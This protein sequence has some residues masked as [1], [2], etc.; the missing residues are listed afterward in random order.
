MNLFEELQERKNNLIALLNRVKEYGWLDA[1]ELQ[2]AIRKIRE[3][4]LTIG[5][6]GQMKCGKSTFL[7]SFIFE[8]EVL[9]AATTPMTAALS[10]ITYGEQKKIVA[11]FY[12]PD[13]WAE[14]RMQAHRSLDEVKGNN[15]EESKVQ[16]AQ[17]LVQRSHVLGSRIDSLLGKQQEDKFEHLIDY[18][19]AEGKYI[20]ITKSVTIYYPKEYLKGV[21]IVDTPGFNDPIVSREERTKAFLKN[22][23]VALMMLFAGRPFDATD[24]DILFKNVRSC[25]AGKVLIGVNKYDIPYSNGEMPEEIKQYVTEQIRGAIRE[26]GE[27][28]L[29]YLIEETQPIMLSAEMALISHLP[30]KRIES[31]DIWKTAYHRYCSAFEISGQQALRDK[32][33]I[34]DLAQAIK[35]LIEREKA[36]ILFRKPI[37]MVTA[38][39]TSIQEGIAKELALNEANINNLSQPD[40]ELEERSV[41]L[42]KA[43]RKIE[44]KLNNLSDALG[45]LASR[46]SRKLQEQLEDALDATI[47]HC[48][49]TIDGIGYF[50]RGADKVVDRINQELEALTKR[51]VPRAK[52]KVFEEITRKVTGE[53]REF[54]LEIGEIFNRYLEDVDTKDLVK[55]ISRKFLDGGETKSTSQDTGA[56][57]DAGS[58]GEESGSLLG[59][60]LYGATL[61]ITALFGSLGSSSK[62]DLREWLNRV[63]ASYDFSQDA[64]NVKAELEKRVEQARTDLIAELL[65]PM[66]KDIEQTREK[67]AGKAQMLEEAQKQRETLKEKKLTADRQLQE[68]LGLIQ[69]VSATK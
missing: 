67:K 6:I 27:D 59:A 46:E 29:R 4:K 55:A 10:Y 38:K 68:I 44:R 33:R 57:G 56:H 26:L 19:G 7:N 43:Q 23:D 53:L 1:E 9:P 22:A 12:T 61:P 35:D 16:A 13:E 39:G 50:G 51:T 54:T 42:G 49:K 20:S 28:S 24:R 41:Q 11:E 65:E 36:E 5:V 45:D 18:V 64:E 8:D 2:K 30:M 32:S 25:G 66:R 37:N 58:Q 48:K 21:E 3:E 47:E 69:T 17:E 40:E 63:K 14:L 62:D 31:S 60:F 34:D 15:L 52:K